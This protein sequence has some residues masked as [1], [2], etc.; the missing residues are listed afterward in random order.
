MM[1]RMGFIFLAVLTLGT[2]GLRAQSF[3]LKTEKERLAKI[4]AAIASADDATYL[5]ECDALLQEHHIN[6]LAW[7]TCGKHLLFLKT[8]DLQAARKNAAVAYTR[9]KMATRDLNKT[10][11][12]IYYVLDALQ[13]QGLA[14]MILGDADRAMVHF[15]T[16]LAR[17]N[18]LAEAW[19]NLGVIYE[20]KGLRDESMRAFDRYVRLKNASAISDF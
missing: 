4:E 7:Y 3:D 1:L 11:K 14:A 15:K 8:S 18:R 12:Q 6:A 9:L 17:D 20:Q 2:V 19:Y 10:G 13:Y 16:A 5:T